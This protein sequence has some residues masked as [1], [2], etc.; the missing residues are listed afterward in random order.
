MPPGG[1]GGGQGPP[2]AA[3]GPGRGGGEQPKQPRV[4]FRGTAGSEGGKRAGR[5]PECWAPRP[6]ARQRAAQAGPDRVQPVALVEAGRV[7]T[8]PSA[9]RRPPPP[10]AAAHSHPVVPLPAASLAPRRERQ[11]PHMPA[12]S[13]TCSLRVLQPLSSGSAAPRRRRC[14]P[15]CSLLPA[16][17]PPSAPHIA[18]LQLGGRALPLW[19]PLQLCAREG[20]LLQ[21]GLARL[22]Q[23]AGAAHRLAADETG[24]SGCAR[25]RSSLPAYSSLPYCAAHSRRGRRSCGSCRLETAGA[26]GAG[27]AA[28]TGIGTAAAAAGAAAAG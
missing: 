27:A 20:G 6:V 7:R 1:G 23:A 21:A 28:A 12:V 26:A 14:R 11:D 17:T 4:G 24:S 3:R 2:S 15:A 18:M 25:C 10:A 16:Q 5:E 9:C 8:L 22:T 19:R 13:W